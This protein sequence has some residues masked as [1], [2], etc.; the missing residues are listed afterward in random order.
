MNIEQ[1]KRHLAL[2]KEIDPQGHA[3]LLKD[4]KSEKDLV[5]DVSHYATK[6]IKAYKGSLKNEPAK[7]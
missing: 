6:A 7:K 5:W 2:L 1:V 4:Y 3:D